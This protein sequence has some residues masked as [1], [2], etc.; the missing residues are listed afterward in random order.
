MEKRAKERQRWS[1]LRA[2]TM[3]IAGVAG[4]KCPGGFGTTRLWRLSATGTAQLLGNRNAG[5]GNLGEF[6]GQR[7][8]GGQR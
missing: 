6:P 3:A 2:L 7:Q 8:I 4:A 1:E 5:Q